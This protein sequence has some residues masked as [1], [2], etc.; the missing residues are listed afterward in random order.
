MAHSS[1]NRA[2]LFPS[3][4][5]LLLGPTVSLLCSG[6][7]LSLLSLARHISP[8]SC[9]HIKAHHCRC[10]PHRVLDCDLSSLWTSSTS[11]VF[12]TRVASY[13]GPC[14][15]LQLCPAQLAITGSL[16]APLG[17]DRVLGQRFSDLLCVSSP[18]TLVKSRFRFSSSESAGGP[19]S[20]NSNK[21]PGDPGAAVLE[22]CFCN[23]VLDVWVGSIPFPQSPFLRKEK[24]CRHLQNGIFSVE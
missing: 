19:G 5:L 20:L 15:R 24:A 18:G 10:V 9:F 11:K 1:W 6:N 16:W 2:Y 23:K 13:I 12:T 21:L 14:I 4:P 3:V 22:T 8:A 17:R 7:I